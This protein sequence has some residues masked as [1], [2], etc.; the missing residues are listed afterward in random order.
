M[1]FW[2][3]PARNQD[4]SGPVRSPINSLICLKIKFYVFFIGLIHTDSNG[5]AARSVPKP[6]Q[7]GGNFPSLLVSTSKLTSLESCVPLLVLLRSHSCLVS[8]Y[9]LMYECYCEQEQR[10]LYCSRFMALHSHDSLLLPFS[11]THE[12]PLQRL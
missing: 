5:C 2:Y 9:L 7:Q 10:C 4:L 12:V 8:L 3:T 11:P 6:M 1:D